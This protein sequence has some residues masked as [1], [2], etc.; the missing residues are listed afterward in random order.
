[1]KAKITAYAIILALHINNFQIDLTV[2]QRDLKLSEKMMIEITKAMRLK[3][4]K[5]K[6]SLADGKEEDHRLGTL[7][8]PL[9]PAQTSDRQ[10][11]RKKIN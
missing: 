9:P 5:R 10:P 6:V 4:S 3:I 2:L 7:S 11:K 8:I 1:M